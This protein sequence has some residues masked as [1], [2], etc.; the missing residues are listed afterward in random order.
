MCIYACTYTY[1]FHMVFTT[2]VAFSTFLAQNIFYLI[3][4]YMQFHI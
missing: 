3:M 1:V 2:Q 4:F